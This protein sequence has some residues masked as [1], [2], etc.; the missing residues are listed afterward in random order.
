MRQMLPLAARI[1]EAKIDILALV[2]LQL[3]HHIVYRR[4]RSRPMVEE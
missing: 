4:H 2:L 3:P 1:G